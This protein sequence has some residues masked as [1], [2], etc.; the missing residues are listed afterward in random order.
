MA[1]LRLQLDP[2][3]MVS[4]GKQAETALERVANEAHR[5]ETALVRAGSKGGAAVA[6]LG[7]RFQAARGQIQNVAFQLGDFATQVGAGTSASVALGQQLP[8]LLGGFGALG[9]VMGAV[10]AIGVP[11]VAGFLNSGQEA[12]SLADAI[13]DLTEATNAYQ[14]SAELSIKS[15][16]DLTERYGRM[17]SEAERAIDAIT[18]ADQIDAARAMADA[19]RAVSDS[20]LSWEAVTAKGGKG[21]G[22]ALQLA[23]DF[24]MAADKAGALQAALL[25][26]YRAKGVENQTRAALAAVAALDAARDS[27]GQL[28]APLEDA[29]KQLAKM[30]ESGAA[31]V[32]TTDQVAASTY[33]IRDAANAAAA[34]MAGIG[35]AAQGAFGA[36]AA[37]A[38]KAWEAAQANVAAA[39]AAEEAT[40]AAELAGVPMGP[41]AVISKQRGGGRYTP[42]PTGAGLPTIHVAGGGGGGGSARAAVE[43]TTEAVREG[44]DAWSDYY[45]TAGSALDRL[46]DGTA[47]LK[48][49]MIDMVKELAKSLLTQNLGGAA[50]DSLGATIIRG[51]FSGFHDTGGKIG[52]G[53][54]GVVGEHGPEIVRSTSSGAVVTSRVD[55]ARQMGG[56][57]LTGE[58]GVTV[59]DDGRLQAYVKRFS[60]QAAG[61]AVH[62]V[63][64][65]LP[66]WQRQYQT[67]GVI[68]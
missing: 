68:A 62:T 3:Q 7:G 2:S 52:I 24:G 29:Y 44:T 53:Q 14:R 63:K 45:D 35:T 12:K 67:D 26:L 58:I 8:Q 56:Q 6:G 65:N 50:G 37:L 36:V 28:P 41:D 43:E 66:G 10:V 22:T 51:I 40:T 16:A 49:A 27:A 18:R 54:V 33:S 42:R 23:D 48:E 1:G 60:M 47:S 11:L 19:I 13:D 34:S 46:I 15:V 31:L 38:A 32:G 21:A 61:A 25:E 64:Q 55:T 39:T 4:G 30:A 17:A 20:L 59:D 57:H 9:A 5:T